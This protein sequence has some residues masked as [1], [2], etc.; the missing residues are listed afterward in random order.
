MA[1]DFDGNSEALEA[2]D[3]SIFDITGALTMHARI[4]R[5]TLVSA[6]GEGILAKYKSSGTQRSYL[7]YYT[8]TGE[9]GAVVSPD[10]SF[11]AANTLLSTTAPIA[12][13]RWYSVVA[14]FNPSTQF[15]LLVD[16]ASV[17]NDTTSIISSIHNG[18][19]PLWIGKQLTDTNTLKF[20]GAIA[21]CAIWDSFLTTGEIAALVDYSPLLIR[22]SSLVEYWPLIGRTSPE[23]GLV[24]GLNAALIASPSVFPHPRVIYPAQTGVAFSVVTAVAANSIY[25]L[26][27]RRRRRH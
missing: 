13:N 24:N 3:N 11:G 8:A 2:A 26:I 21:E 5:T 4:R 16:G 19:A 22:P 23:I 15:Q 12:V 1:R 7:I 18:T 9:M 6:A 17:D 10:G 27:R 20:D 14:R 25:P